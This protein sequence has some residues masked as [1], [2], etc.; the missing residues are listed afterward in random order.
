MPRPATNSSRFRLGPI[1]RTSTRAGSRVRG[2]SL[3]EFALI[4][5]ILLILVGGVIQYGIIFATKQ[6]L[7][8]VGRDVG[9]WAA[10]QSYTPCNTASTQTPPQPV[11]EADLLAQQSRVLGYSALDWNSSNFSS[12]GDNSSLP[13]SPPRTEG[14]E[15]VWSYAPGTSCP[16]ADSTTAAFVTIRLTHRAPIVLPGFGYLPSL[17]TCDASGCYLTVTTTSE[18]RIEPTLP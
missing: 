18:F 3:V 9:R 15:V 16:P 2:Q 12:Y 8:Q 17:G 13:E 5:P 6:A 14:V 11:T 10:T 4:L 1:R 7:I